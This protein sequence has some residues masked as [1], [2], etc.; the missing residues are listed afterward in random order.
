MYYNNSDIK[1]TGYSLEDRAITS[2]HTC[3]RLISKQQYV[4]VKQQH[5]CEWNQQD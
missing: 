5:G 2:E 1:P 4:G 3:P